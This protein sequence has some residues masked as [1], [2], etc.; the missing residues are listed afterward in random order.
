MPAHAGRGWDERGI[1]EEAVSRGLA[2]LSL[3]EPPRFRILSANVGP[4]SGK[5]S[6]SY[7]KTVDLVDDV[8]PHVIMLQEVRSKVMH[9]K[10]VLRK[11]REHFQA[12]YKKEEVKNKGT[13]CLAV[14]AR[15]DWCKMMEVRES[16]KRIKH[17]LVDEHHEVYKLLFKRMLVV[18]CTPLANPENSGTNQGPVLAVSYHGYHTGMNNRLKYR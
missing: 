2:G 7:K 18:R 4:K 9:K 10:E 14:M 8:D 5:T 15:K 13:N 11:L 3:R 6:N 17:K 16:H 12:I 1:M